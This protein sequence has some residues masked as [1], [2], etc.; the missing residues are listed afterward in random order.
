M[1]EKH[2][3][4]CLSPIN[5]NALVVTEQKLEICKCNVSFGPFSLKLSVCDLKRCCH[6]FLS[7]RTLFLTSCNASVVMSQ[8]TVPHRTTSQVR[9]GG[10]VERSATTTSL[11]EPHLFG[12]VVHRF[13][14]I[15]IGKGFV[16]LRDGMAR[17]L[18]GLAESAGR[19]QLATL[20]Y[21]GSVGESQ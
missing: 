16:A 18:R 5:M 12:V 21:Y 13:L 20:V 7:V 10:C 14:S 11:C 8:P 3:A 6:A 19:L 17:L 1:I 9:R 15:A 4:L 2:Y